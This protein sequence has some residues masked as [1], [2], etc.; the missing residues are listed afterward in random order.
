[1]YLDYVVM[2]E[3][4]P[5][6]HWLDLRLAAEVWLLEKSQLAKDCE[7]RKGASEEAPSTYFLLPWVIHSQEIANEQI[8]H[9]WSQ[10]Y[11]LF[12]I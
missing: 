6:G 4:Y 2:V 7:N 5:L 12:S 11:P 3:G 10:S 1:M 8:K 9:F